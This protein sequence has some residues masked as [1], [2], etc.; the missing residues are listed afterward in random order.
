VAADVGVRDQPW[1]TARPFEWYASNLDRL[2]ARDA[3]AGQAG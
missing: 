3:A 2:L 1:W